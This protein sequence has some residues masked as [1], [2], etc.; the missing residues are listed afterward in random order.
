MTQPRTF[1]ITPQD[2][3]FFRDGRPF[4][5]SDEGLARAHSHFPPFPCTMSGAVRR[6]LAE[7]R[8][9]R[10]GPWSPELQA[11]LGDG[12]DDMGPLTFGPP[13]PVCA[14]N[15]RLETLH[16]VPLALLGHATREG[17]CRLAPGAP[18]Q[19]DLG[20]AVSLPQLPEGSGPGWKPLSDTWVTA[21]GLTRFLKGSVPQKEEM[22][23]ADDLWPQESR[24]GLAR[25]YQTRAA[26]KGMLYATSHVR[27]RDD[28]MLALEVH[29]LPG[30]WPCPRV[31][32]LGGEG[33]FG[34]VEELSAVLPQPEAPDS[35][36]CAG[37]RMFYTVVLLSPLCPP[38]E[39]WRKPGGTLPQLPGLIVSACLERMTLIG[40]W[41]SAGYGG[42]PA[43]PRPLRPFLPAGSVFFME[44]AASS[45]QKAAVLKRHLTAIG[46]ETRH[47]FG[48]MAIGTY[49]GREE[50][51]SP[52]VA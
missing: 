14:A 39:A 28:I 31:M 5:Q 41:N 15:G 37:Q 3:L 13:T 40:G 52:C 11:I 49:A 51:A 8:G 19:S 12:P 7:A 4:N 46:E 22:L 27:L 42:Q 18:L 1:K 16:P 6:A 9:W 25:C 2:T 34:W 26:R 30:D 45:E 43:G 44:M 32:P 29:G 17:Y 23:L 24:I 47:G 35:L 21:G 38:D 36:R 20:Q 33:R 10:H 48:R 50:A